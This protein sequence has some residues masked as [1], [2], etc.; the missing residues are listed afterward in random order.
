MRKFH[1]EFKP[2]CKPNVQLLIMCHI[3]GNSFPE[4]RCLEFQGHLLP[5]QAA[6]KIENYTVNLQVKR[7]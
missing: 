1:L 6:A 4:I 3:F 2:V 7:I 5:Q